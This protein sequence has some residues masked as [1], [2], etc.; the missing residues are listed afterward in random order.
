MMPKPDSLNNKTK[1]D[2]DIGEKG[3]TSLNEALKVNISL[4]K[5]NLD[6]FIKK[7]DISQVKSN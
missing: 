3:A 4:V 2:N 7:G 1:P 5:L 6:G